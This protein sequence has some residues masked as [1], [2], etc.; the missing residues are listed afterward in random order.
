MLRTF[1]FIV[2]WASAAA[3]SLGQ[4]ISAPQ[5]QTTSAPGSMVS[6]TSEE[7]LMDVVV[8]DKKGRAVKNLKPDDVR[9]FDNGQAKTIKSFRLIDGNEAVASGG[10]RTPLEPP[11]RVRSVMMIFQCHHD[12]ARRL[13]RDGGL[14]LLKQELALNVDTAV[15]T[16]DQKLE[17][18]QPYTN[19]PASLREAIERATSSRVYDF[20][21]NTARVRRELQQA[22]DSSPQSAPNQSTGSDAQ[23]KAIMNQML[24]AALNTE[25]SNAVVVAGRDAIPTAIFS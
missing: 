13:A 4:A 11:H 21:A 2:L 6:A 18:L 15:M 8:R 22:I 14:D 25:H 9:V 24:L 10:A 1:Y 19:D 23:A 5:I 16:I 7:V 12:D 17:V 20:A 3:L